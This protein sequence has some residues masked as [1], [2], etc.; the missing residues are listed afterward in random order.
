MTNL[1]TGVSHLNCDEKTFSESQFTLILSGHG[2]SGTTMLAKLIE[3][4][5]IKLWK[6][7][8]SVVK[9]DIR[10]SRTIEE[11]KLAV[12]KRIV[13]ERDELNDKW[14][15][16]RPLIYR[17]S[18]LIEKSMRNPRYIIIFRDPLAASNR[19]AISVGRSILDAMRMYRNQFGITVEFIL[20]CKAPILLLSYEKVLINPSEAIEAVREFCGI[21]PE[22]VELM[23]E[24]ITANHPEYL[25]ATKRRSKDPSVVA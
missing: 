23:K 15:F 14:S 11:G 10:I 17:H 21:G 24:Q 7:E 2:R 19:S 3:A 4:G 18:A 13:A 5:G 12:L 8:N 9:E 25:G 20:K 16:K 22:K 1:N 6:T